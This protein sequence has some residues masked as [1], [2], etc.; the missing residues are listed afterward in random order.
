MKK[1]YLLTFISTLLILLWIYAAG[2]K[3]AEYTIFKDQ[4]A[5]QPLPSWSIPLLAWALPLIELVAVALLSFQQTLC[6]GFFLSFLLMF[7]FTV[8]IGLGLAHVYD[9][10]PCSC[11]GILGKIKWKGHLI[12]NIFFL[13]LSLAGLLLQKSSYKAVSK[14]YPA[15]PTRKI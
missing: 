5:R 1:E 3:L 8:Y 4:L 11:G 14:F 13:L 2:S 6:K 7:A 15:R 10:I 9:K 12:F